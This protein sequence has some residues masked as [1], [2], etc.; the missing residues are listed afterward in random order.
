MV[1]EIAADFTTDFGR[2]IINAV[3]I[4]AM[5]SGNVYSSVDTI[6]YFLS[7]CCGYRNER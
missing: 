5:I 3:G 7:E 6:A 1:V 4:S 2:I